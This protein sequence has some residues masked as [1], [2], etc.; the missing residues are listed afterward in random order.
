M[1]S[2]LPLNVVSSGVRVQRISEEGWMD[3]FSEG[4][5]KQLGSSSGAMTFCT[6]VPSQFAFA[7][8]DGRYFALEGGSELAHPQL[9]AIVR[10]CDAADAGEDHE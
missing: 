4:E 9:V 2:P 3:A 7:Q 8:V 1:N 5:V 10:E 6:N